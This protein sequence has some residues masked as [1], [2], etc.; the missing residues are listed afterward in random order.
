MGALDKLKALFNIEQNAPLIV[1][2]YTNNSNNV[3]DANNGF[4]YSSNEKKLTV[5]LDKLSPD[6]KKQL[7]P[8]FQECFQEEGRVLEK[9]TSEL[10]NDLIRYSRENNRDKQILAF[11]KPIIPSDDYDALEASLYLDS[12]FRKGGNIKNLKYDIIKNYGNRGKNICNLASAGYFQGFL[13]PVYN[14]SKERFTEIYEVAV[15]KGALAVFVY[16]E[17]SNEQIAT[18]ITQKLAISNKYGIRGIYIHGFGK[19]N[20]FKIKKC[21]EEKKEE[22]RFFE[23]KIY[24]NETHDIIIVELFPQ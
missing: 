20:V 23:K 24:E 10:L 13:M 16:E 4:S 3:L 18:E 15:S 11:F 7:K 12:V 22:F 19:N 6:K 5:F 17:M 2:N 8:I 1:L 9:N 21:L 14:A